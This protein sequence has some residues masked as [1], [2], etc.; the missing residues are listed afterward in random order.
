MGFY[1]TMSWLSHAISPD[2]FHVGYWEKAALNNLNAQEYRIAD[3][4]RDSAVLNTIDKLYQK[5]KITAQPKVI[6][7]EDREPNASFIHTGTITISTGLLNQATPDELEVVLAHEIAH[8][9]QN[10]ANIAVH[11]ASL[12]APIIIGLMA[13]SNRALNKSR[14]ILSTVSSFAFGVI[15]SRPFVMIPVMAWQRHR[16]LRADDKAIEITKKPEALISALRKFENYIENAPHGH[17]PA[18]DDPSIPGPGKPPKKTRRNLL[19]RIYDSHPDTEATR[20][21]RIKRKASFQKHLE[22][23]INS[24]SQGVRQ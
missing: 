19:E 18:T 24:P 10:S 1:Q 3:R 15:A 11:I 12:A 17:I 14:N 8:Q 5:Y 6:L 22:D 9:K 4:Q 20:I 16:E 7:Y 2:N 23:E 21:P 13:A